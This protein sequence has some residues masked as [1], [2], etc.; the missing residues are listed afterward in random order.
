M[1][2]DHGPSWGAVGEGDIDVAPLFAAGVVLGPVDRERGHT[3]LV[4]EDRRGSVSLVDVEVDD[5]D[6]ADAVIL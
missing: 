6:R 3:R 4:L 2:D 5:Q 1:A